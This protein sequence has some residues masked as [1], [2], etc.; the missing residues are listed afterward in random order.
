M[1]KPL[2]FLLMGGFLVVIGIGISVYAT[3][4]VIENL[5][6]Q[7]GFIEG[8]MTM[9]VYKELNPTKNEKGCM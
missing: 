4:L 5:T 3:Q 8:G 9:E 7:E 6:T 1:K 2:L